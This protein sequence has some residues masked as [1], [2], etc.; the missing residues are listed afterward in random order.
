[1]RNC[2]PKKPFFP[3][4]SNPVLR[5]YEVISPVPECESPL[6]SLITQKIEVIVKR[7]NNIQEFININ[8]E[9]IQINGNDGIVGPLNSARTMMLIVYFKDLCSDFLKPP[10]HKCNKVNCHFS[11]KPPDDRYLEKQ[12][13]KNSL[14]DGRNVY[15]FVQMFPFAL[16]KQYFP[17]FAKVFAARNQIEMLKRLVQDYQKL[18]PFDEFNILIDKMTNN[19]WTKNNA[20]NF[21]IENHANSPNEPNKHSLN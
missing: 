20:I 15:D 6:N 2:I 8:S 16:R 17:A 10:P 19:G 1:M 3:N 13:F 12:L 14:T 5:N 18:F 7:I 21:M 4:C 9:N 11:H